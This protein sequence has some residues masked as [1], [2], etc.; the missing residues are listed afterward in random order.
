MLEL[1]ILVSE[2]LDAAIVLP[3]RGAG[4]RGR[5]P[6]GGWAQLP[7]RLLARAA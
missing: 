3:V 2:L 5:H 7:V 1:R 4:T 6:S